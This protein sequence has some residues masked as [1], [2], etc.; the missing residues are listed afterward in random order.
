MRSTVIA[1]DHNLGRG[2]P[3]DHRERHAGA[4]RRP[5]RL[6]PGSRRRLPA[7]RGGGR[8][9]T[10]GLPVGVQI[11][12]PY[13]R[14]RTVIAFVLSQVSSGELCDRRCPGGIVSGPP[15]GGWWRRAGRFER[16]P[17]TAGP[18]ELVAI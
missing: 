13:L 16:P 14:D 15:S 12:E 11:A 9:A 5:V 10:D 8:I 18:L 1:R 2:R 7:R 3:G 6:G 4:L 17:A